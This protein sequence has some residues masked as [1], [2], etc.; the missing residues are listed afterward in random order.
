MQWLTHH[1]EDGFDLAQIVHRPVRRA[2]GGGTSGSSVAPGR[3]PGA[4]EGRRSAPSSMVCAARCFP[5]ERLGP[6]DLRQESEDFYVGHGLLDTVLQSLLAQARLELRHAARRRA[7]GARCGPAC[8]ADRTHVRGGAAAHPHALL[9][10]DVLAAFLG[11]PR[12]V[13]VW[14]VLLCYPGLH[15]M[16]HHRIAHELY[17][18]GVPCWR[19]SWPNWRMAP[20]ARHPSWREHRCGFVHRPRH[21]R[22]DRRDGADCRNVRLF[23]GGD[24][25]RQALRHRPDGHLLGDRRA[26]PGPRDDVVISRGHDPAAS[27]SAAAPRSRQRLA[28]A[29]RFRRAA[30]SRRP[31]PGARRSRGRVRPREALDGSGI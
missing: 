7:G 8:A 13:T 30:M 20:P 12:R 9:D 2:R 10:S 21:R 15:A 14:T 5:I 17:R 23:P 22:R 11:D 28:D 25:G 31:R 16:I 4:V 29:R 3:R 18:L 6:P 27:R 1:A 19:G 26:A 24:L